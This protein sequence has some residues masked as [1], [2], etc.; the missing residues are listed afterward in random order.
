MKRVKIFF[1]FVV[2]IGIIPRC[3]PQLIEAKQLP[4][5]RKIISLD[6]KDVEIRDALRLISARTGINIVIDPDVK[7][8]ITARFEQP[9]PVLKALSILLSS[10]GCTF[11][12]EDN[13]IRVRKITP[14]L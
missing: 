12:R 10:V 2:I 14:H 4:L 8:K 3:F 1:I 9:V 7:G 5:E 11:S 13:L 6:F